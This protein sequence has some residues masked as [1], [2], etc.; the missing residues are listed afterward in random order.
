MGVKPGKAAQL[1]NLGWGFS[2]TSFGTSNCKFGK[3]WD[4]T[5]CILNRPGLLAAAFSML[6]FDSDPL[7]CTPSFL[8]KN[9][10]GWIFSLK[11]F[12][13]SFLIWVIFRGK[14]GFK[15]DQKANFKSVLFL[16]HS[17]FWNVNQNFWSSEIL[18]YLWWKNFSKSD[19]FSENT[20]SF[21]LSV[22]LYLS[23]SLSISEK[24]P[25]NFAFSTTFRRFQFSLT[26]FHKLE[27]ITIYSS[28]LTA[29]VSQLYW[30][31]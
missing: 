6:D 7:T 31:F 4:Q 28:R 16:K 19:Y 17:Y 2:E 21:S 12:F 23:L 3:F 27:N 22:S 5:F 10:H 15:L 11:I 9:A 29:F 13:F 18:N 26:A 1:G 30:F 14:Q 24:G 25:S 8:A 20:L